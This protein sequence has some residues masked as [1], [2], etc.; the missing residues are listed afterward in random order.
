MVVVEAR[1]N[2]F[3]S[4]PELTAGA[5]AVR[6]GRTHTGGDALA[7]PPVDHSRVQPQTP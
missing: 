6:G 7:P 1:F 2:Q 3:H 5:A 4:G